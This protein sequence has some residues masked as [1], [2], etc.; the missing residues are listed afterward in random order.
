ML[1]QRF[2][3]QISLIYGRIVLKCVN[4]KGSIGM[5][6]VN[7]ALLTLYKHKVLKIDTSCSPGWIKIIV[8]QVCTRGFQFGVMHGA[9]LSIKLITRGL[10]HYAELIRYVSL[11]HLTDTQYILRYVSY[12]IQSNV[13]MI[14]MTTTLATINKIQ[15]SFRNALNE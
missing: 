8:R 2:K 15:F 5:V 6:M 10:Y 14:N 13:F 12:Y 3:L 9:V 1:Q 11:I 7:T 4:L